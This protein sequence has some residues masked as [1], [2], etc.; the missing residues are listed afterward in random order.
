[1]V[2]NSQ[3]I[4]TLI[5]LVAQYGSASRG[6]AEGSL[7]TERWLGWVETERKKKG[8]VEAEHGYMCVQSYLLLICVVVCSLHFPSSE[9]FR[10]YVI[11]NSIK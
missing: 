10:G 7:M 1:M 5:G 3:V 11:C 6:T 4:T 9:V 2:C 8:V